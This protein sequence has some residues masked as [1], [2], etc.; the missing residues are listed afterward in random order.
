M[1]GYPVLEP[2]DLVVVGAGVAAYSLLQTLDRNL[3]VAHFA[4][5]FSETSS[6]WSM[7]GIAAATAIEDSVASHIRDTL[8]AGAGM[9]DPEA[10]ASIIG[11][12]EDAI[13]F[14]EKNG[15]VFAGR[16]REGGHNVARVLHAGDDR[17]GAAIMSKLV[18]RLNHLHSIEARLA[19]IA[20]SDGRAA[21]VWL[22]KE[23][24]VLL[25]PANSVVLAT[26]GA[27]SLFEHRTT[28]PGNTG[29]PIAAA[30]RAGASLS[31][32]EFIQFHPTA[33]ATP[34]SPHPL[35]TEA[36]RGAGALLID[37]S[38]RRF[39]LD[40]DPR[41]E[42]ATRDIV[43]RAIAKQL[44][45]G[46]VYLDARPLG[47]RLLEFEFPAFCD[48]CRGLGLD[49]AENPIP[50][51][52]AAHYFIG[53]ITTDLQGQTTLPGLYAAGECASTGLHG[54]NRL[55]SNSLLE[56][57]VIGRRVAAVVGGQAA[58]IGKAEPYTVHSS[59]PSLQAIRQTLERSAGPSRSAAGLAAGLARLDALVPVAIGAPAAQE[60]A[61]AALLAE[62]I[63]KAAL[64]RTESV[65]AHFRS[66][67]QGS[68]PRL[69]PIIVD[70][71]STPH[72]ASNG[73]GDA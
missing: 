15:V 46:P 47:R 42:L 50:V 61:G 21:G 53:G 26:G 54:A 36:L 52:P 63:L 64:L 73:G 44:E 68:A 62:L 13:G 6:W 14:L 4:R 27:T 65:G 38:G 58:P 17:I 7:G 20:V 32:L 70:G 28:P 45:T 48:G 57:V 22:S 9:C 41:G 24:E 33:I 30:L 67:S 29:T 51:Q 12:A 55:A 71:G 35:A 72:Y 31:G 49:P 25:Q 34:N 43:A 5:S 2:V 18:E 37:A 11:E 23:G 60:A 56:G 59:G 39:A 3:R 69:A 16:G 40:A 8:S 1:N 10:V 66:D 19:A